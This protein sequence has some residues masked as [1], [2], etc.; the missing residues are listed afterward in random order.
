MDNIKL[1]DPIWFYHEG[2]YWL[3]GNKIHEFEYENNN[4][5]YVYYAKDLFAQDW[6]SHPMNPIVTDSEF[7]RNAGRVIQ[8]NKQLIRVSQNCAKSYGANVNFMEI[9]ELTP[10][11]YF[12]LPINVLR[13]PKGTKGLHTYNVLNDEIWTDVLDHE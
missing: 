10:S 1:L 6:T 8:K 2:Y 7:A 13:A 4:A 12:E 11:S 9:I 5:L 3:I